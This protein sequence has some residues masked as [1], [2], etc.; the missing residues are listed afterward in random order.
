MKD[1]FPEVVDMYVKPSGYTGTEKPTPWGAKKDAEKDRGML[2]V[3]KGLHRD[4]REEK[5]ERV[6][7]KLKGE[8][9]GETKTVH[10]KGALQLESRWMTNAELKGKHVLYDKILDCADLRA[11]F[12]YEAFVELRE[13]W[14][15]NDVNWP[16]VIEWITKVHIMSA[17][18]KGVDNAYVLISSMIK[19]GRFRQKGAP[20]PNL[21]PELAQHARIEKRI[22]RE[23]AE[24]MQTDEDAEK[25]R[26]AHKANDE[27]FGV[28]GKK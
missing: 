17:P 14:P 27:K 6:I 23:Y 28:R 4:W 12:P 16:E 9:E 5:R 25:C 2:G 10:G 26:A 7:D 11:S 21:N 18:G 19:K 1:L 24:S 22:S 20:D 13:L 8:C 15:D 3:S